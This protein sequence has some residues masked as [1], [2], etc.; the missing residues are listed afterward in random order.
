MKKFINPEIEVLKLQ[1]DVVY[2][3][4]ESYDEVTGEFFAELPDGFY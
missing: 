2:T 1:A 3:S 4:G